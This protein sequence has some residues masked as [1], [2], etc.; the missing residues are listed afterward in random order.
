MIPAVEG[1]KVFRAGLPVLGQIW[2]F[3]II[4][5]H[6][7]AKEP[8]ARSCG[9]S[10]TTGCFPC[11]P[12]TAAAHGYGFYLPTQPSHPPP[13]TCLRL[14]A[15]DGIRVQHTKHPRSGSFPKRG[16]EQI[17]QQQESARLTGPKPL[18]A[19]TTRSR[20]AAPGSATNPRRPP[21]QAPHHRPS[22]PGRPRAGAPRVPE[23]M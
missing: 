11:V 22:V 17:N 19:G 18:S 13:T 14:T 3:S 23:G 7:L 5:G 4:N 12:A 21:P 20:S 6:S 16:F 15:H 10:R 2:D 9:I 8:L 1:E